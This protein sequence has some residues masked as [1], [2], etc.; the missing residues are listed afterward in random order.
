MEIRFCRTPV[1]LEPSHPLISYGHRTN[2][3]RAPYTDVT[4][5]GPIKGEHPTQIQDQSR[6][7]TLHRCDRYRTNQGRAPYP[8]VTDGSTALA[9]VSCSDRMLAC[10]LTPGCT[11]CGPGCTGAAPEIPQIPRVETSCTSDQRMREH[12]GRGNTLLEFSL[13]F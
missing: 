1:P 8:D 7:S 12:S 9:G 4:N 3:G 11:G 5:T 10:L 6:A 2:Q 13:Q